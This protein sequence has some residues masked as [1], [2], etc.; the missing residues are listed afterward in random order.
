MIQQCTT[1]VGEKK[2]AVTAEDVFKGPTSHML[3]N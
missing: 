1:A 3:V 2:V